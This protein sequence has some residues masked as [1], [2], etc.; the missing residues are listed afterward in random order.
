[1]QLIKKISPEKKITGIFLVIGLLW[2]LFSDTL[3]AGAADDVA[4]FRIVQTYKGWFFVLATGAFLYYLLRRENKKVEKL[5]SQLLASSDY[6][7]ILFNNNPQAIWIYDCVQQKILEVN[8]AAIALLGYSRK[9]FLKLRIEDLFDQRDVEVLGAV[10]QCSGP[11]NYRS[12]GHNLRRKDNSIAEIELVSQRIHGPKG[13]SLRL[14]LVIDITGLRQAYKAIKANELALKESERQMGILMANLPGM[15]YRCLNDRN[16]TMLFVSKGCLEL[17]GYPDYALLNNE[18][19]AFGNLIHPADRLNLYATFQAKLKQRTN[20]ST[21][22]RIISK[23]GEIKWVWEQAVGVYDS[24]GT[25]MFLEGFIMDISNQKQTEKA[26][27]NQNYL[28]RAIMNNL[29]FPLFYKDIKGRIVSCNIEFE[30]YLG[31]EEGAL[32]GYRLDELNV[33]AT[34]HEIDASDL[35][36]L[37]S[38]QDFKKDMIITYPD[39]SQK[40]VVYHKTLYTNAEGVHQGF[41]GVYFD[42][43]ERVK[44][45]AIIKDQIEELVRINQELD[46]FTYVVSHDL[47]SPLVTIKGSLGFLEEDIQ[48]GNMALIHEGLERV[49]SAA[50]KM[51]KLIDDLLKLSRAGRIINPLNWFSM[52]GLVRELSQYLHGILVESNA[53]LKVESP[54]PDVFGDRWRISEVLQNL[55]ENAVKYRNPDQALVIELGCKIQ[56]GMQVFSLKD[57][58]LGIDKEHLGLVFKKFI[59]INKKSDGLGL[60]LALVRRVVES[61]GGTVWV[62]SDGLGKGSTFYFSFPI[63]AE[64]N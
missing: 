10:M 22:Y 26:L 2:I 28:L 61:H 24:K 18:E 47:R 14:V 57:N 39:G 27:V 64:F 56:N 41:I 33:S 11:A 3:L 46:Q 32:P 50:D 59:S 44:N 51:Q 25:L 16:Y 43:S 36:M 42:I 40:S 58:G 45:E 13:E 34:C 8:D 37:L 15:A 20:F 31:L 35:E 19:V 49:G 17:T 12:S 53:E 54:L 52:E 63:P 1:L 60:G 62:E 48:N 30:K 9:D 6:Y 38:G 21:T 7:S 23:K 29:P 4:T 55:I 5:N